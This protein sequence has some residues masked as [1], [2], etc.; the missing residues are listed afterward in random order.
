MKLN[1]KLLTL[2]EI[3]R[4]T[5]KV[6]KNL[7]LYIKILIFLIT[8]VWIN[9]IVQKILSKNVLKTS[10]FKFQPLFIKFNHKFY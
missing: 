4:E 5:A 6:R 1:P 10:Y 3:L 8:A 7:K 9:H 2:E